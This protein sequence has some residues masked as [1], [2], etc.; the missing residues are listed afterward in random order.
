MGKYILVTGGEL[1]NKG[2]EAMSFATISEMKNKFPDKEVIF[3]STHDYARPVEEK[4]KFNFTILPL[5]ND[6]IYQLLGGTSRLLW[7]TYTQVKSSSKSKYRELLPEIKKLFEDGHAM[8]DIS[9]YALSSQWGTKKNINYLATISIAE[10]YG[11][12]HHIMPQS[13]GPFEFGTGKQALMDQLIKKNMKYP[14]IIYA[15]E[16]EG[17]KFLTEQ[18]N[19]KNVVHSPDLVLLNKKTDLSNIYYEVPEVDNYKDVDGVGIAP[20]MRNF[21]YGDS[22]NILETYKSIVE[23]LL[24]KGIKVYL[25]RHAYEDLEVCRMIKNMFPT[26]DNVVIFEEELTSYEFH[27]LVPHFRFLIGSRYHS[28]IHAYKNGVPSIALGWATKYRELLNMFDQNEYIFDVRYEID[29]D[30]ILNAV[31]KMNESYEAESNQ[32]KETLLE[33]QGKNIYDVIK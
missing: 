27:A 20:N 12:P 24:N 22:N 23:F 15:R 6:I 5:D 9:G 3:F 7:N 30:D 8:V 19:L 33:L 11:I 10:K 17:Y 26:D 16:K 13:M 29:T 32:I 31:D 21:D 2:A 28:I 18:Y 4:A 14:N 1:F 25:F